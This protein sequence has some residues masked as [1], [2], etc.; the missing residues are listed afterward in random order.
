MNVETFLKTIGRECEVRCLPVAFLV[1]NIYNYALLEI[2]RQV[3]HVGEP[4]W[5][6]E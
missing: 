4:D 2:H 3:C 5:Q 1:A 6:H